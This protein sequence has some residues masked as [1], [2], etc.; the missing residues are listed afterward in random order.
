MGG[1]VCPEGDEIIVV[2]LEFIA[3][4]VLGVGFERRSIKD[5]AVGEADFGKV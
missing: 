4:F 5:D 3:E 1:K 2:R